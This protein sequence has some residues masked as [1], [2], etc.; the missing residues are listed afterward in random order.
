MHIFVE[1]AIKLQDDSYVPSLR[2]AE[3]VAREVREAEEAA[4]AAAAERAAAAAAVA[5][6]A[7]DP[8][9]GASGKQAVQASGGGR[10]LSTETPAAADDDPLGAMFANGTGGIKVAA[11]KPPPSGGAKH[12]VGSSLASG[13]KKVFGKRKPSL[14]TTSTA[15][16]AASAPVTPGAT[17]PARSTNKNVMVSIAEVEAERAKQRELA[18]RVEG[19][20]ETLQ[21]E[22]LGGDGG[23]SYMYTKD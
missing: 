8:L 14:G 3:D 22:L 11:K 9:S 17:S 1:E 21:L 6:P 5:A 7:S 20:I 19:I 23:E 10:F 18:S 13:A 4:E 16:H 12:S 15:R 2:T